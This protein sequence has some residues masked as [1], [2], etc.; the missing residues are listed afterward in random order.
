[1]LIYGGD[2]RFFNNLFLGH[3]DGGRLCGSC[4]T[5]AYNSYSAEFSARKTGDDTPAA[6][7]GR[8]LPVTM[9][10]NAYLTGAKPWVH[11]SDA[12]VLPD[13]SPALRLAEEN[14]HFWLENNLERYSITLQTSPVT[15]GTLGRA[16]QPDQP[17]ED[18]DGTPVQ[19][20]RD[21]LGKARGALPRVGPLE[22]WPARL[23]LI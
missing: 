14:G 3:Q 9:G 1:M 15:A 7:L 23:K 16:F 4:G 21:L 12:Q 6:D 18:R 19:L 8:T 13:A 11:E 17:F 2:N 22:H 10:A 5:D 20:G